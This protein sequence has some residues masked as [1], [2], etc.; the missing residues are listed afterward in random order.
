M[1]R[2]KKQTYQNISSF[3]FF[4]FTFRERFRSAV[5]GISQKLL[6]HEMM[7]VNSV[8]VRD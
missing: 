3:S 7:L 5:K 1:N 6:G 2:D 4:S 8:E